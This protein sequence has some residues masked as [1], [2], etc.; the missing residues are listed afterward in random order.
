[1]GF[2]H[3]ASRL[4]VLPWTPTEPLQIDHGFVVQAQAIADNPQLVSLGVN[5]TAM[6]TCVRLAGIV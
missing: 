3:F 1:M 4:H 5:P 6:V 2:G